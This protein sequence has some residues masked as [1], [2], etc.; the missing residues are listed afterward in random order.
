MPSSFRKARRASSFGLNINL[1]RGERLVEMNLRK[2]SQN[3]LFNQNE[4]LG[5]EKSFPPESLVPN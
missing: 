1:A 2:V 3:K 4:N 5:D